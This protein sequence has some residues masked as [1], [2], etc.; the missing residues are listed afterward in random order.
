MMAMRR[1]I[2]G[3]SPEEIRQIPKEEL[4]LPVSAKDFEVALK[5]VSKSVSADD[6]KKYKDWMAE[7][8]SV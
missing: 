4:E 8:G 1:R 3:L 7:Y 2:D 6:I 5:K